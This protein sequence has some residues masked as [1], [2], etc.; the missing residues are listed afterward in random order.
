M[1]YLTTRTHSLIVILILITLKINI[2]FGSKQEAI[3]ETIKSYIQ[4][5]HSVAIKFEQSDTKGT[6]ARGILIIDKPY[7]FRVNY[8]PP[9]PLL[10]VGNKNYV[11]VYDYEMEN[12][13][14]IDAKDN[15][16]NFL[17]VDKINFENQFEVISAKD[18]NGHYKLKLKHLDSG[19]SSEIVFN[20][21]T[22]HI[23]MM[24]IFEDDNII[25]L[26]FDVTKN[27]SKVDGKLFILQDPD[28][29]GKP[30]RLDE[31]TLM[32]KVE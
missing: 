13:S 21:T 15:I 17:L 32:K 29:Y 28:I 20:K 22:H 24:T 7:K 26:K 10:I 2:A 27:L 4:N 25:S 1:H 14:R 19:R 8:L 30:V 9:F 16:F 12:L 31:Q 5:I 23:T 18:D 11:S 3:T 6:K